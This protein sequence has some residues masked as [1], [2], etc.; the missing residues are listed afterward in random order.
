[1][2]SSKSLLDYLL[3]DLLSAISGLSS[4]RMFSG[5]GIYQHGIIFALV[6]NGKLYFKVG[7]SN[8]TLYEEYRSEPFSYRRKGNIA[9]LTSYWEVPADVMED[10]IRIEEWIEQSVNE[11]LKSKRR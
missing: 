7:D 2:D 10:K 9:T 8:R 11:S 3:S 6:I 4:K 5:Y 1:M